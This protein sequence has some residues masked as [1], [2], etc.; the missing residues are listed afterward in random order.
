[1]RRVRTSGA[2]ER[3]RQAARSA[4]ETA[5]SVRRRRARG[6]RRRWQQWMREEETR[7]LTPNTARSRAD[8]KGHLTEKSIGN[9]VEGLGKA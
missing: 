6:A 4:V 3:R 7:R 5:A 9:V 1:M 8:S 2:F